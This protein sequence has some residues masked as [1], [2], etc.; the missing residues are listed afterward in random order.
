MGLRKR[1]SPEL[2]HPYA[3][4]DELSY[5]PRP[6]CPA[7]EEPQSQTHVPSTA[8]GD[9]R[10]SP[11]L[12]PPTVS[13]TL[14]SCTVQADAELLGLAH[15]GWPAVWAE[16]HLRPRKT[17]IKHLKVYTLQALRMRVQSCQPLCN[18]KDCPLSTR[19]LC[20]CTESNASCEFFLSICKPVKYTPRLLCRLVAQSYL[21][22]L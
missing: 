18:A 8:K 10:S 22:L 19:L 17:L 13:A 16:G 3:H 5:S 4:G 21:T 9:R 20:P 14:G 1:R 12:R 15:L 11:G 6:K 7:T 2:C